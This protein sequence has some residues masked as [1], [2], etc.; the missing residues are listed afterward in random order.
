LALACQNVFPTPR[1]VADFNAKIACF[2][3]VLLITNTAF[4]LGF[5]IP[6]MAYI[7]IFTIQNSRCIAEITKFTYP[8]SIIFAENFGDY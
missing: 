8:A 5:N 1:A 3:I 2:P 4:R 6:I 7:A